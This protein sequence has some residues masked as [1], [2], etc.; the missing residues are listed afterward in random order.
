[1]EGKRRQII[2][3]VNARAIIERETSNGWEIIIQM[4]NK[5]EEG[6]K[7]I[8]LPGGRVEEFES[9][10]DALR[11]EVFEEAGLELI[12]IEGEESRLEAQGV[13]TR[14][15]CLAPFCTYQT[16]QGPVDSMGLYFR[17]QAR[18]ELRSSGDASEGVRWAS[19]ESISTWL[20]ENPEK[21]SW[22]DR[23]GI[24]FYL[25]QLAKDR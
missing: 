19:I 9:F 4:R 11:R 13:A 15:E 20:R 16:L 18:G 23:A 8:E 6:G 3:H 12:Y 1:L 25:K 14:V 24:L 2:M 5:P 7:W 21:F 10:L 17:C 22:V